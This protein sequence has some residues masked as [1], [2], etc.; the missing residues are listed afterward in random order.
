MKCYP[1]SISQSRMIHYFRNILTDT[2]NFASLKNNLFNPINTCTHP[3]N[4]I[5][6]EI[7]FLNELEESFKKKSTKNFELSITEEFQEAT[8][9]ILNTKCD[10]ILC[11]LGTKRVHSIRLRDINDKYT[12][13]IGDILF[14]TQ[15]AIES[16]HQIIPIYCLFNMIQVKIAD[17][18]NK[19]FTIA[20]NQI[21]FYQ[22]YWKSLENHLPIIWPYHFQGGEGFFYWLISRKKDTCSIEEYEPRCHITPNVEIT[23]YNL[24]LDKDSRFYTVSAINRLKDKSEKISKNHSNLYQ[25]STGEIPFITNILLNHHGFSCNVIH[26]LLINSRSPEL[27]KRIGNDILFIEFNI[28][29]GSNE[30][31]GLFLDNFLKPKWRFFQEE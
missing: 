30:I 9:S 21:A 26:E 2:I 13:E 5:S 31:N 6:S 25:F 11:Q 20:P 12:P 8:S 28:V 10:K 22:H 14:I 17:K 19:E 3:E 18:S 16:D 4:E 7:S 1:F 23:P 24:K 15:Y 29:G 27:S